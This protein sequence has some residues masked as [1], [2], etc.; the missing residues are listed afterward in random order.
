M[1]KKA[2]KNKIDENGREAKQNSTQKF[3]FLTFIGLIM[4]NDKK[5]QQ[6]QLQIYSSKK[7]VERK[8]VC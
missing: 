7:I 5:K 1:C 3:I 4:P 6:V 2:D 8:I